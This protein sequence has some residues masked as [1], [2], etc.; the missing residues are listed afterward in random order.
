MNKYIII[1]LDEMIKISSNILKQRYPHINQYF[2]NDNTNNFEQDGFYFVSSDFNLSLIK[3][4]DTDLVI[5]IDSF[6][7]MSSSQID[8]YFKFI[9]NKLQKKHNIHKYKP[10]KI[11]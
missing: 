9:Y 7:E 1:D 3:F 2:I 8:D 11:P 5:N 6:Q 4:I 10:K